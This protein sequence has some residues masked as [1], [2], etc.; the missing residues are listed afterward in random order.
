MDKY[1]VGDRFIVRIDE[2]L[3]EKNGYGDFTDYLMNAVPPADG[4]KI[5]RIDGCVVTEGFLDKCQRIEANCLRQGAPVPAVS[6]WLGIGVEEGLK[7]PYC[8]SREI[9]NYCAE[10]GAD[11]RGGSTL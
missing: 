8:N 11:L 1:R 2:V 3:H 5:R 6:S 4:K 9:K 10:C 7:C